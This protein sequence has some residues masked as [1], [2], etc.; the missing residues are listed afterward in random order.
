MGT[1][2]RIVI[3]L[4]AIIDILK[5]RRE[6]L[7]CGF[8]DFSKAFDKVWRAGLWQKLLTNKVNGNFLNVVR[9]MYS[10]MKSCVKNREG[11]SNFFPCECGVR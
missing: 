4:Y 9:N 11:F 1:Q 10:G 8:I 7:Y 3:V 6:I 5:S 2:H